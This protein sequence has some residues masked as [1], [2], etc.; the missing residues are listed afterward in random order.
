M[1]APLPPLQQQSCQRALLWSGPRLHLCPPQQ[2]THS[3]PVNDIFC[4][5]MDQA[6]VTMALG[7]FE[8]C[9]EQIC[10]QILPA[11]AA[12]TPASHGQNMC[13]NLV[14]RCHWALKLGCRVRDRVRPCKGA[15]LLWA[16][17]QEGT[18]LVS[19]CGTRGVDL[20]LFMSE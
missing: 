2:P 14:Y 12:R 3:P 16:E 9:E 15:S 8:V 5:P 4:F 19:C 7:S 10:S 6:D 20:F 13:F 18:Q 17:T 1:A 11:T